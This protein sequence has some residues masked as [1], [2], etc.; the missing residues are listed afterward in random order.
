MDKQPDHHF[1]YG[2]LKD[3]LA[4]VRSVIDL[5]IL[6]NHQRFFVLRWRAAETSGADEEQ[7]IIRYAAAGGGGGG[8]VGIAAV[9][10]C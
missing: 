4:I 1:A 6:V 2:T 7:L 5:T 8:M 3:C 9:A 10:I